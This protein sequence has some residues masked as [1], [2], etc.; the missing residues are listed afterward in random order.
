MT[1][2]KSEVFNQDCMIGMRQFP[3]KYFELAIVD[4]PYGIGEDGRKNHTRSNLAKASDYR[5]YSK[6]DAH[7]PD[8]TYFKELFRVS[9]NQII[10][11]ANHYGN[12]PAASG[13]IVWDKENGDND[14]A[15]C[16]LAYSSFDRAVRKFKYRWAG[17]LQENMN[18]KQIRIHP[19]EKPFA[20]YKWLLKT[21]ATDGDKIIDTHMGSQASRIA[22]H[23]MAFEYTGYEIDT[24]Y[25]ADGCKRFEQYKSQLKLF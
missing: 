5:N 20:L 25:F 13:W 7:K 9:K 14:F 3:D 17:M 6:Y 1:G 4:P 19:N 23:D 10:W 16:E 2:P 21:Y 18:D 15:D 12:M 11:G 22:A 24:N 8:E